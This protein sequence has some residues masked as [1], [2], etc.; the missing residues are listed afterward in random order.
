MRIKKNIE[1]ATDNISPSIKPPVIPAAFHN[2]NIPYILE[3]QEADNII[4]Y[5]MPEKRAF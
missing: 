5:T 3:Q 4:F 2:Q 1:K